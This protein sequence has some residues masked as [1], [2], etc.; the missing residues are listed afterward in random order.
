LR[1][2]FYE[3]EEGWLRHVMRKLK[4]ICLDIVASG[5]LNVK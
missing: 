2:K 3:V 5:G 1:N 4:Q